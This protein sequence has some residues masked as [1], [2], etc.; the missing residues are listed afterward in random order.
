MPVVT[1]SEFGE[2]YNGYKFKVDH[3]EYSSEY[4]PDIVVLDI[5]TP[6]GEITQAA[7]KEGSSTKAGDLNLASPFCGTVEDADAIQSAAIWVWQGADSTVDTTPMQEIYPLT[8]TPDKAPQGS[9]PLDVSSEGFTAQYEGYQFKI[10]RLIYAREYGVSGIV[11]DVQKPDGTI[12]EARMGYDECHN[13]YYDA[14]VDD[15]VL[16]L[17]SAHE[18]AAL[19][20]ARVYAWNYKSTPI[21]KNPIPPEKPNPNAVLIQDVTSEGFIKEY[22]GYKFKVDGIDY[23][24]EYH[25][26]A[27]TLD[28]QRQDGTIDQVTIKEGSNARVDDL[29]IASPFCGTV[30]DV[31]TYQSAAIWVW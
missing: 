9:T 25:A 29:N 24:S 31:G 18:G 8:Y 1:S 28:V 23:S 21:V 5:E 17:I 10:E 4:H 6:N 15:T 11:L 19:Q 14:Q 27:L 22:N 16:R 3:L 12:V 2:D 13:N 30:E 26:S 7:I 20:E